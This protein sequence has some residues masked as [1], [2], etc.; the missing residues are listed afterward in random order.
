MAMILLIDDDTLTVDS[1]QPL[2]TREGHRLLVDRP[3]VDTLRHLVLAQPD[4]VI[5]GIDG[6]E[7]GWGY[8]RQVVALAAHPVLLLLGSGNDLDRAQGLEL[9]A[10]DCLLKPFLVLELIARVRALLRR[11]ISDGAR[12]SHDAFVDGDLAVDLARCEVRREGRLVW[13]SATEYRLLV[14]FIQHIDELLTADHLAAMV[15]GTGRAG[16]SA[17]VKLYVYHLRQKLEPDPSHPRRL[18]TRRGQ[19]Y[20]FQRLAGLPFGFSGEPSAGR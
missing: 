1:L 15:W 6:G 17:Q 9:G 19:G 10:A 8:M 13:L 7:H 5:L 20:L 2:L 11:D 16:A 12:P 4:L 14:C 18:L 3:S